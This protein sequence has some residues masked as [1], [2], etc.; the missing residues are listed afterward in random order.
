VRWVRTNGARFGMKTKRIGALGGSAGAHLVQMLGTAAHGAARVQAVVSWSGPSDLRPGT[1]GNAAPK[2]IQSVLNFLGCDP[3]TSK[4]C[5]RRA[6]KASPVTHVTPRSAP[7]YLF[8][9]EHEIVPLTGEIEMRD[10]LR[11]AGVPV[12][13]T[14][15]PGSR[16]AQGYSEDAFPASIAWLHRWLG[17]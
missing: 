13:L 5:L 6:A 4:P 14:V 8:N 17:S 10:A 15:Y 12:R 3:R 11:R 1:G 2:Q 9:S 16:H 7:T